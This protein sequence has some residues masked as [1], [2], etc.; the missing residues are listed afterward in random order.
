[1]CRSSKLYYILCFI[2]L[3]WWSSKLYHLLQCHISCHK[4]CRWGSTCRWGIA[5][6]KTPMH[7]RAA[8]N[9]LT[10][11]CCKHSD[12]TLLLTFWHDTAVNI[13]TWH[14][15]KQSPLLSPCLP[16]WSPHAYPSTRHWSQWLTTRH[17]SVCGRLRAAAGPRTSTPEWPSGRSARLLFC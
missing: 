16:R 12:M 8:L 15:C 14:C 5:P 11:H 9:I 3:S 7:H 13:L 6:I 2:N 4:K 17:I 10:W 1:M